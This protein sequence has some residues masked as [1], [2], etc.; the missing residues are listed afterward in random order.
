MAAILPAMPIDEV[1]Q[2]VHICVQW[3]VYFYEYNTHFY[4]HRCAQASL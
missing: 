2:L 3:Y 4:K 1:V